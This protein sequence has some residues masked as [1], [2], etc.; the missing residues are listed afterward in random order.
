[1]YYLLLYEHQTNIYLFQVTYMYYHPCGT[2]Y[3]D[4]VFLLTHVLQINS[5]LL[6]LYNSQEFRC[7]TDKTRRN[8]QD[9]YFDESERC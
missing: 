3:W 7:E 5:T 8:R 4:K 9:I 2:H 6:H 1:M